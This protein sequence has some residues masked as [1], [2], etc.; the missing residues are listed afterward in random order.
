ML[1]LFQCTPISK[2][3]VIIKSIAKK[4]SVRVYGI[5]SRICVL[6]IYALNDK[7]YKGIEPILLSSAEGLKKDGVTI[8]PRRHFSKQNN[9]KQTIKRCYH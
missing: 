3:I 4:A 2:K 6:D 5:R 9:W 1:D 8:Q 7:G